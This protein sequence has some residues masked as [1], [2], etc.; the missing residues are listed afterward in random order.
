MVRLLSGW[1]HFWIPMAGLPGPSV[2]ESGK[3]P[4]GMMEKK[5]PKPVQRRIDEPGSGFGSGHTIKI[6]PFVSDVKQ[7]FPHARRPFSGASVNFLEITDSRY[8]QL[9]PGAVK[10]RFF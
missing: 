5:N 3:R 2:S 10:K 7:L 4:G 8:G 6:R 1:V 9:F